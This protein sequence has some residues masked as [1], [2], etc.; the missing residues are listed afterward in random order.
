MGSE[1][2]IRDRIIAHLED[3]A[4]LD[5]AVEQIK[6]GTRQFAKRQHTWFRNL[7]ECTSASITGDESVTQM[8]Q[9]MYDAANAP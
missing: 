1:M 9:L 3:N 5:E 7:E 4:P 6:T 8:A 2:C